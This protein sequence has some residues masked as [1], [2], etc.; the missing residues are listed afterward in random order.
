MI[1]EYYLN[2]LIHKYKHQ[3]GLTGFKNKISCGFDKNR[4]LPE[5]EKYYI[6]NPAVDRSTKP[7]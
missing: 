2:S 3:K 7:V 5:K 6:N 1:Y 4:I